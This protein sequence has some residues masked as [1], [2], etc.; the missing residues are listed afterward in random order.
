VT[1]VSWVVMPNHMHGLLLLDAEDIT[2]NP[3]FGDVM[4]WFKSI[5]TNRHIHGV[6]QRGWPAY[7]GQVWPRNHYDHIVRNDADLDR[8]RTHVAN[9]PATGRRINSTLRSVRP[10]CGSFRDRS[11][12]A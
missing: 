12:L 4:T 10:L 2:T 7:N 1:L 11:Q 6:R 9:N 8:I 5:T 3:T